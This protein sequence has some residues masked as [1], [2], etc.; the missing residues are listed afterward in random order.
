MRNEKSFPQFFLLYARNKSSDFSKWA[1]MWLCDSFQHK[2][3]LY[4]PFQFRTGAII[5]QHINLLHV[6]TQSGCINIMQQQQ[7]C[8]RS[9]CCITAT[10]SKREGHVCTMQC[11]VEGF[12]CCVCVLYHKPAAVLRNRIERVSAVRC[13]FCMKYSNFNLLDGF[14]VHSKCQR[15]HLRKRWWRDQNSNSC[16]DFLLLFSS[17]CYSWSWTATYANIAV[18]LLYTLRGL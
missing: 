2:V 14:N 9:S 17:F 8:I 4:C 6:C 1:L 10:L 5:L 15:E 12:N 18:H 7:G 16:L 11:R 13:L 3:H